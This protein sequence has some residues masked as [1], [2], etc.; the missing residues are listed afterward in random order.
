[1]DGM[2]FDGRRCDADESDETVRKA[3]LIGL[4]TVAMLAVGGSALAAVLRLTGVIL[5]SSAP[6]ASEAFASLPL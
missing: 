5:T 4:L 1:M 2:N 3:V 6:A